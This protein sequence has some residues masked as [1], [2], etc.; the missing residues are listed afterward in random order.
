MKCTVI[1][2]AGGL[3]KR[4]GG[5]IPKQFT[6]LKGIPVLIHTLRVFEHTPEI[7]NIIVPVPSEFYNL[8]KELIQKHSIAKPTHLILAGKKKQESVYN[9]LNTQIVADS[10]IVLVHDAVRPLVSVGLVQRIIEAADEFGAAVPGIVVEDIIKEKT[11]NGSIVRTLDH[12]KLNRIQSPQGFWQE[13]I[14]NA[15]KQASQSGYIG[16]DSASLLEFI[17]YK[18]QIIDGEEHNIQIKTPLDTRVAE[19]LLG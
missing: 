9:A 12:T 5:D 4:Y 13:L 14:V 11:A 18:V 17:G 3:G 2:P 8:A 1:I 19:M 6:D 10:D 15:Y 7:D 16:P